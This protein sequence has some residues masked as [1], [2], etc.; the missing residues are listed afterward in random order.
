MDWGCLP[1]PSSFDELAGLSWVSD[2]RCR[3][4][5]LGRLLQCKLTFIFISKGWWI[6]LLRSKNK[7]CQQTRPW[8]FHFTNCVN[9]SL[10][11]LICFTKLENR[12][13]RNKL[14]IDDIIVNMTLRHFRPGK[15]VITKVFPIAWVACCV[16]RIQTWEITHC[17]ATWFYS[18]KFPCK[19]GLKFITDCYFWAIQKEENSSK[20][21]IC[22][23]SCFT[24][25]T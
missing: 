13:L 23:P 7:T 15:G 12:P 4:K 19:V 17:F 22:L 3:N 16:P 10:F 8:L 20:I 21:F 6:E 1:D 25:G 18:F 9:S 5:F 24:S 11:E 14:V 2:V